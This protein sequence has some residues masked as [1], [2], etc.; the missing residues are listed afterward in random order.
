MLTP[1]RLAISRVAA[2]DGVVANIEKN[3]KR[4]L[5]EFHPALCVNDGTAIIAGAGPSLAHFAQEIREEKAKGRPIIAI[6]SAHD[7]LC[8]QGIEPDIFFTI[9][10][11]PRLNNVQE[12][13]QSTLYVICSRCS[14][15]LF[16]FLQQEKRE[17]LLAHCL[18]SD[19]ENRWFKGKKHYLIGGVS[20]SG[21]RAVNLLYWGSGFRKFIFYGMDSC[22]APDGVTKRVDGSLTGQT[23][24][25]VVGTGGKKFICNLAMAKQ[26]EDFQKLY[27]MMPDITIESRGDGLISAIIEERKNRGLTV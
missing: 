27:Q 23:T 11:R 4:G 7:W 25:V 13:T 24:E 16:D 5:R 19:E 9:D 17:I 6:K 18:S 3:V 14:P 20:T 26:A 1:L 10:P 15:E 12:K 21:L 8:Q 22:N 2:V